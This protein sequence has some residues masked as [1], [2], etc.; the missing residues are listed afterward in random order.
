MHPLLV[1]ALI[2]NVWGI[3]RKKEEK[4][5]LMLMIK[6]WLGLMTQIWT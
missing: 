2:H 3:W 4:N 5:F 6:E 1:A